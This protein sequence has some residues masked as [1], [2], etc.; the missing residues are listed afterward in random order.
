MR[1][2]L[3]LLAGAILA[4]G[5]VLAGDSKWKAAC[6]AAWDEGN[7]TTVFDYCSKAAQDGDA[8]SQYLLGNVYFGGVG[9]SKDAKK[10]AALWIKAAEAGIAEA[11]HNVGRLYQ[12]GIE[13]DQSYT[14]AME[15]YQKAAAQGDAYAMHNIGFFYEK[16]QGVPVDPRRAEDWYTR[17]AAKG[18]P[19]SQYNLAVMY[20]NG[21]ALPQDKIRAYAWIY[22]AA[23]AQYTPAR[24]DLPI[25]EESL[26]KAEREAALKLA[27]TLL[28]K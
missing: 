8:K 1:K 7:P 20:Y 22:L 25:V 28:A 14:K 19:N 21:E 4:P 26:S 13:V 3:L 27:Q 17:A 10:G 23:E 9:V 6:Q 11:Q 5:M 2:Y 24:N 15:W 18:L 16:G 12:K